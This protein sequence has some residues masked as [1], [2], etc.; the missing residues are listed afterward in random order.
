MSLVHDIYY[1]LY[2]V[3]ITFYYSLE[4]AHCEIW[5]VFCLLCQVVI[6]GAGGNV[7]KDFIVKTA[8]DAVTVFDQDEFL[9]GH[10]PEKI[11]SVLVF[12][13][14]GLDDALSDRSLDHQGK[15]GMMQCTD[16]MGGNHQ[17]CQMSSSWI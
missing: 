5:N 8:T 12:D 14:V 13:G 1:T 9:M 7:L 6:P 2:D 17:R 15:V 4:S 16:T 10:H 3:I 11:E